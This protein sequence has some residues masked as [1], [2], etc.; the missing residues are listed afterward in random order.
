MVCP[1][2][3]CLKTA[4]VYLHIINK[5]ILKRKKERFIEMSAQPVR[6]AHLHWPADKP[7]FASVN[8]EDHAELQNEGTG[9]HTSD[10][11]RQTW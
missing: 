4:T 5:Y 10:S 6:M 11:A 2:L 8:P 1:L 7:H 3:V 9:D